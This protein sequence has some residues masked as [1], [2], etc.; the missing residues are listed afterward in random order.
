MATVM[1]RSRDFKVD[2]SAYALREVDV[3]YKRFSK[4]FAMFVEGNRQSESSLDCSICFSLEKRG[5]GDQKRSVD[6]PATA[7][8]LNTHP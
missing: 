6:V 1:S 2:R 3:V 8:K 5:E 4:A 7:M